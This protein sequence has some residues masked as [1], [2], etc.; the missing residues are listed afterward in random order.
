MIN[1]NNKKKLKI[2]N[3]KKLNAECQAEYLVS[4]VDSII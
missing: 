4:H 3:V 1:N 2:Y